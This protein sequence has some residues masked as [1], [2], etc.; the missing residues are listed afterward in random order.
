MMKIT[1]RA[2]LMTGIALALV[3][4]LVASSSLASYHG[5]SEPSE[6]VHVEDLEPFDPA[7]LSIAPGTEVVWHN[8]GVMAHTV[9]LVTGTGGDS[10]DIHLDPGESESHVFQDAG[11]YYVHCEINAFHEATMHQVIEVG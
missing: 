5:Q 11:A 6:H 3:L 7:A 1:N 4:P 8:H 2:K 9:T 10:F